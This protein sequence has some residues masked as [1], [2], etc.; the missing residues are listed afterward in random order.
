VC[1]TWYNDYTIIFRHVPYEGLEPEGRKWLL[2][3][4]TGET[5]QN[6]DHTSITWIINFKPQTLQPQAYLH[7]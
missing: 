4:F 7:E 5:K 2:T 3:N 6:F 1:L